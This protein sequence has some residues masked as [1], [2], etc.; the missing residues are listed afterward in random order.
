MKGLITQRDNYE[1]KLKDLN[2]ETKRDENSVDFERLGI[3]CINNKTFESVLSITPIHIAE[4]F[5]SAIKHNSTP[6]QT[7]K[8]LTH[9]SIIYRCLKIVRDK[10]CKVLIMDAKKSRRMQEILTHRGYAFY[11]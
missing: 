5:F 3:D 4:F 10:R 8:L 7:H 2:A 1:Q 6:L 11:G 9:K